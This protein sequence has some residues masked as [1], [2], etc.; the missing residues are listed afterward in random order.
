MKKR[1][2]LLLTLGFTAVLSAC[3]QDT[4]PVTVL[5]G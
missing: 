5:G 1:L 4:P 2:C 3:A